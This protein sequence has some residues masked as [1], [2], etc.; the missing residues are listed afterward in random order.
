MLDTAR[1]R[2]LAT[3]IAHH[4]RYFFEIAGMFVEELA[5]SFPPVRAM[6]PLG[7]RVERHRTAWAI[8][9][10]L[11]NV[12]DLGAIAGQ[13]DG[14][15]AR[16]AR[17]GFTAAHLPGAREALITALRRHAGLAWTL[18]LQDDWTVVVEELAAGMNLAAGERR[19]LAA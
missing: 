19:R 16:L 1:S 12:R 15:G 8:A 7:S 11:K 3:F 5:R 10:V 14:A 18:E 17:F 9:F 13:I 4:N 6:L 2:R